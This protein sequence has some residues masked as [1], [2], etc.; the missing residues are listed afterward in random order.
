MYSTQ[1]QT[2]LGLNCQTKKYRRIIDTPK[3]L[4]ITFTV[5]LFVCYFTSD[6]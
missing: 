3:N 2:F 5:H 4:K 1:T 6:I